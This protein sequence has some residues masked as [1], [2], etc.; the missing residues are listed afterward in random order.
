MWSINV[1]LRLLK[2]VY[3][4]VDIVVVGVVIV[5]VVALFVVTGHIICS[6]GQKM[7]I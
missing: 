2:A 6:W 5:V 7:L 3:F 4:V 1:N